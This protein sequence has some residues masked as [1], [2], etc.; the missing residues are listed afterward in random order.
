M[1]RAL[2]RSMH[3]PCGRARILARG[4]CATCYTLKRQDGVY[5][6]GLRE[7]VLTRN[8]P[9]LLRTLWREQHP[10]AHEQ[11]VLEFAVPLTKYP[12][13]AECSELTG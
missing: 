2:Q 9:L 7:Q 13:R 11:C 12:R 4:L 8:W 1:K 10:G 6:G 5:F 3:C